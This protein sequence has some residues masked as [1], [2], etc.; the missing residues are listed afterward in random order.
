[1]AVG[2]IGLS[3]KEFLQLTPDEFNA[4]YLQWNNDKEQQ[5][6]MSWEQTRFIAH[7]SLMPHVKKKLMPTDLIRFKWD[8]RSEMEPSHASKADFYRIAQKYGEVIFNENE[9]ESQ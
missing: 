2:C 8:D 4:V 9:M 6:K 3:R 5:S 7:C 1:L